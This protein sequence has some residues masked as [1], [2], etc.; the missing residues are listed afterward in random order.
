[1]QNPFEVLGVCE[2]DGAEKIRAAYLGKIKQHPPDRDPREFEKIR[3]AY[4]ILGDPRQRA[5]YLLMG[6]DPAAP[7]TGLLDGNLCERKFT[8]WAPWMN[9]LKDRK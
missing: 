6:A 4:A 2:S 1:M 7:L 8:G 5:H 9:L 3:D